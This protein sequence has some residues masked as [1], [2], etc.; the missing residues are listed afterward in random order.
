MFAT[1]TDIQLISHSIDGMRASLNA[2]LTLNQREEKNQLSKKYKK[3]LDVQ[4]S[5]TR[6]IA[7][8]IKKKENEKKKSEIDIVNFPTYSIIEQWISSFA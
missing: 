7:M 6:H 3:L 1:C 8:W 4:F 2:K 5:V